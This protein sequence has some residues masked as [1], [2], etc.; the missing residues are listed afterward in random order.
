LLFADTLV[1]VLSPWWVFLLSSRA[2]W[3][4]GAVPGL[5]PNEDAHGKLWWPR[6]TR[7]M[8]HH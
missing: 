4:M 1:V 3:E 2:G 7:I 8:T 6:L 5:Y